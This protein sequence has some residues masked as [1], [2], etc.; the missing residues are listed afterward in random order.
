MNASTR[1]LANLRRLDLE[2][3]L[4]AQADYQL[5][6]EIGG[7]RIITRADG[8]YIHDAEGNAILDGMAG[9]WCVNV[10]YGRE[11][12]ARVAYDQM[13]E[14]PYYNTFF[15]TAS[16]PAIL[17]AA[18]VSELL[19]APLSHVFFNNSGSEAID[20]IIRIVR[21]YWQIKGEPE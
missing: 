17:L 4:P 2:H 11:E 16:A 5:L 18:K 6:Q 20:T 19:G 7:S 10:G 9:L 12:L 3:H 21:Y 13:R 8:C 15:R 14:L 1:E